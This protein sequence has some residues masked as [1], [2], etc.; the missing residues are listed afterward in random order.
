MQMLEPLRKYAEFEGRATRSE[1]WLFFLFRVLVYLALTV[2]SVVAILLTGL[3]ANGST[4]PDAA[5]GITAVLLIS[6]FGLVTLA[7]FIPNLAVSVRRLHDSDKSGFWLL[8]GFIPFGGFVVF[9][10]DLLDGTP[11]PN[12]YGPDPKGRDGFSGPGTVHHHYHYASADQAPPA[13]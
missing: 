8:L 9:I 12:R 1:Y 3:G 6:L 10:F 5:A 13:V 2:A 7:L 4:Q 11:G